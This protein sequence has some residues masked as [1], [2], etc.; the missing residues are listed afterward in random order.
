MTKPDEDAKKQQGWKSLSEAG[1]VEIALDQFPARIKEAKRVAMA[2]LSEL[3]E[4]DSDGNER[5]AVAYSLGML[6]KLEV[7]VR[8]EGNP[9][10][11]PV[12]G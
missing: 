4:L 11:K 7:T 3:M 9:K 1:L 2:R 5:R 12:S 10:S 8:G 6:K